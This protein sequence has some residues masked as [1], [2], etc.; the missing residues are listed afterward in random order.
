MNQTAANAIA[1][2]IGKGLTKD[3]ATGI[4]AVLMVESALN[5]ASENNTGT[6]T[7]GSINPTGSYGLAQWNGPRQ[8]ALMAFA[9]A[10]G[11]DYSQINT[12]LDFVLTESANSYPSV[13]AAMRQAGMT[14]ANF[15]PIF[16]D[17]YEDPAD[18]AGEIAKAMT[19]AQEFYAYTIPVSV[20][21]PVVTPT[22]SPVSAPTVTVPPSTPTSGATMS[23][24]ATALA[25]ILEALL[26][27][28][29]QTLSQQLAG[30]AGT[31]GGTTPSTPA[32][33]VDINTIVSGVAAVVVPQLATTI[34]SIIATELQKVVGAIP[35]TAAK[36]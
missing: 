23:A 25:P 16:V 11:L 18:K 14:Y 35:T 21:A 1:H 31:A 36:S 6:E 33:P 15:I 4:V 13:W 29:A 26:V 34:Q 5:P 7:P 2:Y 24:L 20:P 8:Q 19:F 3:V 9:S 10:K 32:Q 12:Q 22:P 28:F 30:A 27:A 17:S